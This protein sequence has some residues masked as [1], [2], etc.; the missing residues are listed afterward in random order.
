MF[1]SQNTI[2]WKKSVCRIDFTANNKIF[3][4][5]TAPE[6]AEAQGVLQSAGLQEAEE[7]QGGEKGGESVE[8]SSSA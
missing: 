4:C 8:E 3:V 6:G 5:S 7:A 2:S 1:Q